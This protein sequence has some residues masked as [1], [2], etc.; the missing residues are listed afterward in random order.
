LAIFLD[1]LPDCPVQQWLHRIP[2][3]QTYWTGW[4]TQDDP[5]L[6]GAFWHLT[7]PLILHR[8]Q[9]AA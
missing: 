6:N 3:N 4:P 7:F 8:L 5:Y 9:P 1:E 2:M